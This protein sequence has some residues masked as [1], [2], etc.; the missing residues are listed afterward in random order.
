MYSHIQCIYTVLANLKYTSC[1]PDAAVPALMSSGFP[2][3]LLLPHI[4]GSVK[5][6]QPAPAP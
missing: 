4:L 3:S 6:L 5:L 2:V 1:L